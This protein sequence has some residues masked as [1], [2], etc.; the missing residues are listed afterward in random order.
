MVAGDF[1]TEVPTAAG[2]AEGGP[3]E[4]QAARVAPSDVRCVTC[5]VLLPDRSQFAFILCFSFE[6]LKLF[7]NNELPL[8]ERD[9]TCVHVRAWAEPYTDIYLIT[10]RQ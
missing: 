2:P 5:E 8:H 7:Y 3:A 9:G 1:I 4:P 6:G 10:T